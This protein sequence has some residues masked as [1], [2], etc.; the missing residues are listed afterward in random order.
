MPINKKSEARESEAPVLDIPVAHVKIVEAELRDEPQEI[1]TN[2]GET[3]TADPNLNCMIEVVDDMEE[4]EFDGTR[5]Y[6]SFKLKQ[7]ADG[8]WTIRDGTKLAA[9]AKAYYGNDFFETDKV[10][11]EDDL[12]GFVFQAKVEPKTN[13]RTK[14]VIGTTLNFETIVRIPVSK[15]E[16]EKQAQEQRERSAQTK[17]AAESANEEDFENI[18]F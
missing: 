2:S 3:F 6:D 14:A 15:Q 10:F 1:T 12:F 8:D 11:D 17:Q 5:F 4:G 13:F 16:R 7:D 9:L 18:P